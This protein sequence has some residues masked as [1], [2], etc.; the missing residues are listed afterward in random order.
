MLSFSNWLNQFL[1]Q[2]FLVAFNIKNLLSAFDL[3]LSLSFFLSFFSLS[4]SSILSLP[5]IPSV[6]FIFLPLFLSLFFFS[7]ELSSR[8]TLVHSFFLRSFWSIQFAE[9]HVLI[10]IEIFFKKLSSNFGSES[11]TSIIV[12]TILWPLKQPSEDHWFQLYIGSSHHSNIDFYYREEMF[13]ILLPW[14]S[15]GVDEDSYLP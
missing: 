4:L 14:S 2:W 13:L 11:W 3:S 1:V 5:F 8:Q 12:S 15:L 10:K 9:S 6:L 7:C